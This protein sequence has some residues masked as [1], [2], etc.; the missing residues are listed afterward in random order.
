M[1]VV[2]ERIKVASEKTTQRE[3]LH[4]VRSKSIVSSRRGRVLACRHAAL[5]NYDCAQRNAT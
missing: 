5:T 4:L 2:R 3:N 1:R